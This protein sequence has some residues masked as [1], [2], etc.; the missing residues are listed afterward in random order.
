VELNRFNEWC[1]LGAEVAGEGFNSAVV[2]AATVSLGRCRPT[3][4]RRSNWWT[5]ELTNLRKDFKRAERA[6]RPVRKK[7]LDRNSPMGI[8]LVE[9]HREARRIYH[10]A[11]RSAKTSAWKE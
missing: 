4:K 7:E 2:A 10:Q 8:D 3:G 6:L 9:K 1:E 11:M 5:P